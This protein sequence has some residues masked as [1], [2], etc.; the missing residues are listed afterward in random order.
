MF[1]LSHSNKCQCYLHKLL[2]QPKLW[3]IAFKCWEMWVSCGLW[4]GYLEYLLQAP[5]NLV[6]LNLCLTFQKAA[7]HE[8]SRDRRCTAPSQGGAKPGCSRPPSSRESG[9]WSWGVGRSPG[10]STSQ[11]SDAS[12][13]SDGCGWSWIQGM[14]WRLKGA[15]LPRER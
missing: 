5:K 3:A 1:V 6:T 2:I 15:E 13:A 7:L 10:A 9:S 14:G 8:S 4:C 12:W 11:S